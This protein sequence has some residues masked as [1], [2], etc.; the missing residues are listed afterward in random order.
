M[1]LAMVLISGFAPFLEAQSAGYF[2]DTESGEP[3]FMQRLVWAG[4]E[5][6]LRYEIVIEREVDGT[7]I[8]YL[9]ESLE[10]PF[11]EISLP[12]GEYRYQVT[13]YDILDRPEQE[14]EWVDIEVRLAVQPELY[15]TSPQFVPAGSAGKPAGFV[16]NISGHNLVPGAEIILR[17][18]DGV[19]I[20][21]EVLDFSEDGKARVFINSENLIYGEYEIIVKNPGGL[22]AVMGGITL[23]APKP[24]PEP[25]DEKI[26]PEPLN[27]LVFAG[28]AWAPVVPLHGN[29]FGKSFS[30]AGAGAHI[31]AALPIPRGIHIGAEL[32]AFW[33]LNSAD[34][35]NDDS[36]NI[37]SVGANLLAMKWLPNQITALNFKLGL[38]CII[39]P[40][41]QDRLMFN[42][43][44]SYL[45]RFS[46]KFLLEAGFD[47][48]S[49]IKENSFDGCIRPWIGAGMIL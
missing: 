14:S 30:P 36:G 28:A 48:A 2:F 39:L 26:I 41:T 27:L 17:Q 15:N 43:G 6:A 12:P 1:L 49:R 37:L 10:Q 33:H 19:E 25:E 18:S 24:E 45:W 31:G 5:Y 38:S 22:G 32:T 9:Q 4:G 7:Y 3:H 40:D 34:A 29:F 8:T 16:L 35:D 44:A 21:P 11:I 46:G 20:I 13:S 47:Y 23:S 42:I